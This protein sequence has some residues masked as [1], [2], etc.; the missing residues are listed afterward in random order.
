MQ[1][2]DADHLT[3]PERATQRQQEKRDCRTCRKAQ[4]NPRSG[5]LTC[6]V[7][8]APSTFDVLAGSVIC[9]WYE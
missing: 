8:D 4:Y 3:E 1:P 7:L 2:F 6:W 9:E 5:A